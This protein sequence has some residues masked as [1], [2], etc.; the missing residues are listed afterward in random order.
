[1]RVGTLAVQGIGVAGRRHA[2]A[3][4]GPWLLLAACGF[5]Q[6]KFDP[7]KA[8]SPAQI[9]RSMFNSGP[10]LPARSSPPRQGMP[11]QPSALKESTKCMVTG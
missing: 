11:A 9:Q 2:L 1:M 5:A 6:T 3:L 8:M 10:N 4:L 7:M